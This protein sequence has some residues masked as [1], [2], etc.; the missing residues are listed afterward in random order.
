MHMH[1]IPQ[2]VATQPLQ[3]PSYCFLCIY[4][5]L[6]KA[7]VLSWFSLVPRPFWERNG[8]G[9]SWFGELPFNLTLTLLRCQA[10]LAVLLSRKIHPSCPGLLD[11][12]LDSAQFNFPVLAQLQGRNPD[13]YSVPCD[14]VAPSSNQLK[15]CL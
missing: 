4:G 15:N 7:D 12:K 2:F 10:G 5:L 3:P 8:P 9:T 6:F 14:S 11:F 13:S 1:A